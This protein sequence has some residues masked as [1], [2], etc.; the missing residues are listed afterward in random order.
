MFVYP[1]FWVLGSG[2]LTEM[3][4]IR[5]KCPEM[6]TLWSGSASCLGLIRRCR[7][8]LLSLTFCQTFVSFVS[9]G[10]EKRWCCFCDYCDARCLLLSSSLLRPRAR[11]IPR[12]VPGPR[13]FTLRLQGRQL[14]CNPM[15]CGYRN[16]DWDLD[17]SSQHC[18]C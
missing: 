13:A 15:D 11:Q 1:G 14:G 2:F 10:S 16:G 9:R 18:V 17:S 4:M 3:L 12:R 5:R 7:V 8:L 6:A